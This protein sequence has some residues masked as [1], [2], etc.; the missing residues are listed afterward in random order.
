MKQIE[1]LKALS[2][3]PYRRIF[4]GST[5]SNIGTWVETVTIGI[6]MQTLTGNATYVASAMAAG[7]IP[8]ALMALFSGPIADKFPRK[9]TLLL[10][11]SS[12]ALIASILTFVVASRIDN[13]GLIIFLI[14]LAGFVNA[15]S[16]PAW[17]AFISDIVPKEKLS[18]ALSLMFAQW[19]LG[20]IIG[21]AIASIFVIGK[22][23]EIAL[24][25]NAISFFVVVIMISLIKE[26]HYQVS[27][28]E[29]IYKKPTSKAETLLGGW[30][31]I[32]S[33][34]SNLKRPYYI[35]CLVV[36]W[37]SPFIALV[38]NVADDVFHSENLGTS[39]FTTFQGLGGVIAA[40]FMTT[41]HIKFGQT[42]TQQIFFVL[43]PIA[44]ISF[45]LAPNLLI[46][47]PISFLFGISYLGSLTSTTLA[48]QLSAPPQLRGRISAAYM[49]TLGFL[50]PLS[51]II[52][53]IFV[54]QFGSRKLF[55]FT[56]LALIT[57]LII[58]KAFTKEYRL[59]DEYITQAKIGFEKETDES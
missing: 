1:S 9:G 28:E 35:Y 39:L 4:I 10:S 8:Q 18:G 47:T 11:N 37:S 49:A 12:A 57:L 33:K 23:Y 3:K 32:F 48:A 30:K 14:F 2:Y 20:R 36:F 50:F 31:F 43:L 17:Q 44:L 52:Q 21:P 41:L 46:A 55:I 13:P 53:S 54:E 40:V 56:G 15:I 26:R 25:L 51:S 27:K 24:S 5:T 45:G 59:P 38:P 34:A 19:N 58:S 7:Y 6:Y 42:K 16:F 29:R 22:H